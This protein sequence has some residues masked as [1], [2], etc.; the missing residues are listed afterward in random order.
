[1]TSMIF[2]L[3]TLTAL[4]FAQEPAAALSENHHHAR[5]RLVDLGT[6]GGWVQS[7][8]ELTLFYINLAIT[9]DFN[10]IGSGFCGL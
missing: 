9:S 4:A 8:A 7:Q 3:L 1:M 2:A 6:F 10:D 5:F